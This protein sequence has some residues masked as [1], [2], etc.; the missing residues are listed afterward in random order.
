M[1]NSRRKAF[2]AGMS[3]VATWL[4]DNQELLS[5]T[6]FAGTMPGFKKKSKSH[7][8]LLIT[9]SIFFNHADSHFNKIF[10]EERQLCKRF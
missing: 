9:L 1:I 2:R 6:D 8:I 3:Y 7:D 4:K 10:P 5:D